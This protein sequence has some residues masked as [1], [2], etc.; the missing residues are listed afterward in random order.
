MEMK[1]SKPVNM[2]L[3]NNVHLDNKL[4]YEKASKEL[5]SAEHDH[6]L[7]SK[8]RFCNVNFFSIERVF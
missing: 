5:E 2:K 1:K 3:C 6:P 7:K 4:M 8:F